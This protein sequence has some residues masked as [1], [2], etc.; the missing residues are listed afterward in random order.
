MKKRI[1]Y[2]GKIYRGRDNFCEALLIDGGKILATGSSAEILS[3]AP[4]GA[5]KID[6]AGG[7]VVPGF[8]D[9]HLHLQGVGRRFGV[10]ECTGAESVEEVIH[11]GRELI[12]QV[13]PAPG[14][15]VQGAGV[16][17]DLFT[18]EKRDL[19]RED[20]D[21]VSTTHPVIFARHCGHSIYCNS[22]ALTMAGLGD[23]APDIEG[24]TIEKDANGRPT[25]VLRENANGLVRKPIPPITKAE[26]K[27]NLKQA[28]ERAISLGITALGPNDTHGADFDDT[29]AL[30][31]SIYDEAGEPG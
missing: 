19:T 31:R 21:K 6:A 10:V 14:T 28:M 24:G 26:M 4:A 15:Y 1:V 12:A 27:V 22:L 30:Y 18:G 2:N 9:S 20:L 11:R 3:N 8:H 23:S 16:N 29:I 5:E 13:N 25:G 17:P 7:L